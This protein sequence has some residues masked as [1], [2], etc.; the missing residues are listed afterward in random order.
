MYINFVDFSSAYCGTN[1]L[2]DPISRKIV[3]SRDV[4]FLEGQLVDDGD[5]V[6]KASSYVEI[7]IRIDPVVL[8][9]VHANHKGELQEGNGV[10]ENE[11]YPTVDDVELIEQVDGELPLSPYEP[12]LRRS[13]RERQPSTRYPPNEYVMVIDRGESETYQEAILHES[14]KEWIKAMEE[15]VRSLLEN[16][17]Y[18]LVKLPQGKRALR[19]KWV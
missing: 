4:V 3:R 13:T 18:D 7:P 5:K 2:W 15:E 14:K 11:G 9:S 12:P 1:Q 8:P 19:N 6:E 17:T 10:I 16:H